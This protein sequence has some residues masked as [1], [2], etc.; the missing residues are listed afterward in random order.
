MIYTFGKNFF[1]KDNS[2]EVLRVGTKKFSNVVGGA[3][4]LLKYFINNYPTL[5]MGATEHP[6]TTQFIPYCDTKAAIKPASKTQCQCTR[7]RGK[8]QDYANIG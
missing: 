3:S 6:V 2:I 7:W 1:G 5:K 8:M 4:K